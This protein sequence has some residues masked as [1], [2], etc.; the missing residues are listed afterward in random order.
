MDPRL[1][2]Q[3]T[4]ERTS[5]LQG[6][7]GG[8]RAAVA[9]FPARAALSSDPQTPAPGAQLSVVALLQVTGSGLG[10]PGLVQGCTRTPGRPHLHFCLHLRLHWQGPRGCRGCGSSAS[11]HPL[12]PSPTP[13]GGREEEKRGGRGSTGTP[14]SAGLHLTARMDGVSWGPAAGGLV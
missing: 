9:V 5:G 11:C 6:F 12:P 3:V 13:A 2:T 10:G 7:F 8:G 1:R 4:G 14:S